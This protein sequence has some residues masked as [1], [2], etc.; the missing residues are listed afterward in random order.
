M[1]VNLKLVS[2]YN[3][4]LSVRNVGKR[5]YQGCING[6]RNMEKW[7]I[8]GQYENLVLAEESDHGH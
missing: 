8:S 7:G 4:Y 2:Y 3:F 6:Y 5:G 1:T